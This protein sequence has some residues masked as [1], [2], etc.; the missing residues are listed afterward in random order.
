MLHHSLAH[1]SQ[2]CRYIYKKDIEAQG[3]KKK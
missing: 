2:Y 1:V 3:E